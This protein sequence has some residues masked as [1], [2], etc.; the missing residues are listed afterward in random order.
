MGNACSLPDHDFALGE[1]KLIM[2]AC[3]HD[4]KEFLESPGRILL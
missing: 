3:W 2:L 4:G 1:K